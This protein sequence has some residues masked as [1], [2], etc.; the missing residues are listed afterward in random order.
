M[1][2]AVPENRIVPISPRSRRRS[3]ARPASLRAQGPIHRPVSS[4]GVESWFV[5]GYLPGVDSS[6]RTCCFIS[7]EGYSVGAG[8]RIAGSPVGG[9]SE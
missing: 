7:D 6:W 8:V 2:E 1:P 5:V 9:K 3:Q 4:S